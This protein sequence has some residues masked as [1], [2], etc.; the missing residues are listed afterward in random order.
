MRFNNKKPINKETIEKLTQSITGQKTTDPDKFHNRFVRGRRLR[1]SS[2]L[3]AAGVIVLVLLII[4]ASAAILFDRDDDE[5]TTLSSDVTEETGTYTDNPPINTGILLGLTE[6]SDENLVFLAYMALDSENASVEIRSIPVREYAVVDGKNASL[7]NHF[8]YGGVNEIKQA[9]INREEIAGARY[10]FC[11][12][13]NFTYFLDCIP[14]LTLDIP[15]TV[16]YNYKGIDLII[17][18]GERELTSDSLMKYFCYLTED[19]PKNEEILT[20]I[21]RCFAQSFFEEGNENRFVDLCSKIIN[22]FSTD[23]SAV[24]IQTYGK[25]FNEMAERGAVEGLKVFS[26]K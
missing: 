25:T 21:F 6:N 1:I 22:Y 24:D 7:A 17:E 9:L 23:V 5:A 14:A 19:V 12:E 16:E 4:G 18:S 8:T 2:K 13:E 26:I 3:I 15:E 20:T 10:V 11:T